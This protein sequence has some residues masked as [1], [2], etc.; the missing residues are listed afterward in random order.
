MAAYFCLT[1]RPALRRLVAAIRKFLV[2][3]AWNP[4][5]QGEVKAGHAACTC[6]DELLRG[7]LWCLRA[8]NKA[9]TCAKRGAKMIERMRK[10]TP[11]QPQHVTL[12]KETVYKNELCCAHLADGMAE[13]P[14]SLRLAQRGM[15]L[16]FEVLS[17]VSEAGS[18]H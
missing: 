7:T 12:A 15:T 6:G 10:H 8:A 13:L 16:F 18:A 3:R 17:T 2:G 11:G 1:R 9:L 14:W 5:A 4:T